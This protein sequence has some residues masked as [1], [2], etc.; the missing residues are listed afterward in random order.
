[1][2]AHDLIY[3]VLGTK[4]LDIEPLMGWLALE[5]GLLGLCGS[6]YTAFDAVGMPHLGAKMQWVRVAILILILTPIAIFLK[7]IVAIAIVRLIVTVIFIPTLFFAIGR[8]MHITPKDYLAAMWR[9]ATA[10]GV[11]AIAICWSNALIL[12]GFL[13]LLFDVPL[14]VAIFSLVSVLLWKISGK[15]AGPEQD[16]LTAVT[17]KIGR[18]T[19]HS[20]K[21][22]SN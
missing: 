1:M 7:S 6:V 15:P 21:L 4:W 22:K 11:M 10:A 12:P 16:V 3:F 17:A 9:P 20:T 19:G 14:G 2:V 8:V 5:A 13:R 18:M